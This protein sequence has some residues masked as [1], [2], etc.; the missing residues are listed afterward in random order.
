[1]TVRQGQDNLVK[2]DA[3]GQSWQ[4]NIEEQPG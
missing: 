3:K 4:D 1:M 2:V